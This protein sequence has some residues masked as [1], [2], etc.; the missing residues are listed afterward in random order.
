M[1]MVALVLVGGILLVL[2]M[3]F[4]MSTLIDRT[5]ASTSPRGIGAALRRSG[6]HV[7]RVPADGF[8][9]N[10]SL[11]PGTANRI[12]GPGTAT[13]RSTVGGNV[14]LDY[15]DGTGR[16]GSWS[17][18][19]P[20]EFAEPV[21]AEI[22]SYIFAKPVLAGFGFLLGLLLAEGG[23]EHRLLV[24]VSWALAGWVLAAIVV[25]TI[26]MVTRTRAFA[27]QRP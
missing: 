12:Y 3:S 7:V 23:T 17:G 20:A 5:V 10:P 8:T 19:L 26:S 6:V 2:L 11:P 1:T 22:S 24:A 18:P 21:R 16:E 9:W 4:T 25:M 15:V 13:Y 14:Q 27:A